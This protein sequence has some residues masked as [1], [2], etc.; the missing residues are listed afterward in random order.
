MAHITYGPYEKAPMHDHP[1]VPAVYIASAGALRFS[2]A[3]GTVLERKP[4]LAGAIRFSSASTESHEVENLSGD[5]SEYLRIELLTEVPDPAYTDARIPP[6]DPVRSFQRSI[7]F[8]NAELRIVRA[9]CPAKQDC[10]ALST[11]EEPALIVAGDK[12][13]WLENGR[14]T[15]QNTSGE[16]VE[17]IHLELKSKPLDKRP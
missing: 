10:S 13:R 16:S 3:G 9:T 8:E 4:V 14:D 1:T 5:R 2:H 17:R 6:T 7:V 15:F 12:L 11:G